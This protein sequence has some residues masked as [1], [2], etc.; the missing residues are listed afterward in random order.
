MAIIIQNISAPPGA[1]AENIIASA[2]KKSGINKSTVIRSGIHKISLD[3]RKQ[4]DIKLAVSVWAELSS[5][6]EEKYISEKR[7]HISLV[8]I[9]PFVPQVT[10]EKIPEGR[11]AVAGFGPAGM[12]AAFV[13][14]E[15]GYRPVVL[16][17][18]A[19]V[20]S[21]TAA[22]NAFWSS[23]S[24]SPVTNVQ[25]G[26]GGAGTFSDGKLTTRIKDPLCRYISARLCEFGAPEE[27]LTKAKPHIGT[28]R[29]RGIVK[30]IR[31]HIIALGGEVRFCSQVTDIKLVDG[32]IKSIEINGNEEMPVSA[33][34]MAIGHSA[35]D[36]FEMLMKRG[37]Y[38]EPKPFAVGARIEHTQE[39]IDRSLYGKHAGDPVLPVGEYQQSF[40]L[41][42][43]GVYT[44]CMCP[45]G[46]VVPS[47]SEENT[48]VTNGMSEFARDGRNANAALVVSVSPDDYGSG[49]LD[50]MNFA[51]Q[52]EQKAFL[53]AGSDYSAPACTVR[54]FLDGKPSLKNASAEPTYA[55][56]V[57]P[58]S[59]DAFLPDFVTDMMK[60]GLRKFS[61][62]MTAFGDGGA[63]LTGPETRTSS[64]VRICRGEDMCSPSARGLYPCGEGAGYA[65]G[66]MSAAVDGVKQACSV[67]STFRPY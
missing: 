48:V 50:G 20:D 15:A 28:D 24:F 22:V 61:R 47:Q 27:I 37:I 36:T 58:C 42:G 31:E 34:I 23:R 14:A 32:V 54:S 41:D 10:G 53:A 21:R 52:I 60:T 51:R 44:F 66:I 29:L 12:F 5:P 33:L 2:L 11:I 26:E 67:M 17:R 1:A 3:A 13:L 19:D 38:M 8:D 57:T 16:E 35:R 7:E 46:T 39:S 45:G 25:F 4:N 62:R 63:V 64:P 43:R 40:T 18:G 65:G 55:C 49:I 9:T 6:E 59:F 30:S 56:G